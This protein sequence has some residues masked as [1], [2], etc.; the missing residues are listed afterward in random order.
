VK[1]PTVAYVAPFVVFIAFLA[2]GDV[3]RLGEWEYPFRVVV[4]GLVLWF[5]SR[6]VIDLRPKYWLASLGVGAAVFIIWVAPDLLIPGYRQH[7][8]FQNSLTGKVA[9]SIPDGFQLS[10]LVLVFRT[11]RAVVIVPLVEELFWRG[12]LMR[13]LI[14]SD[15]EKVPLGAYSHM[16]FWLTAVLF[17][18]EHGPYWEVGLIAGIIYNAWIVRTRCL[19][20]CI[21]AHA[22]TNGIL[23]AFIIGWERWEYWL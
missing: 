16:S 9:T 2:I 10:P 17:A 7:W 21:L 22:V 23:C 11:L 4:L 5:C 8:L 6:H 12:W 20:D 3:F 13:W 14:R 18:S 15:F 1:N 19:A